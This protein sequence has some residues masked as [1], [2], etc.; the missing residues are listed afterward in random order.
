MP[1]AEERAKKRAEEINAVEVKD[2]DYQVQVHIVEVRDLKP[3][4]ANGTSDPIVYAEVMGRKQ[5]TVTKKAMTSCVFDHVMFF[6]FK[7]ITKEDVEAAIIKV[8]VFDADTL[9]RNDLIGEF[10]FDLLYVYYQKHH[11]VHNQ[12]VGIADPGDADDKGLQGYLKLSVVVLGPGDKLFVHDAAKE[13]A[14]AEAAKRQEAKGL[15]AL[16]MMPPALKRE[17]NFL[18]L[19]VYRA[20]GLPA[21]DEGLL[22]GGIDAFVQASFAGNPPLRT[23]WITAKGKGDLAVKWN[24]Q[25]WLP[26]MMPTMTSR[27]EVSVCVCGFCGVSG[28]R[29]VG[30]DSVYSPPLSLSPSFWFAVGCGIQISVWDFD[31]LAKNDR[32]GTAFLDFNQIK[33]HPMEPAWINIYGAPDGVKLGSNK[34]KM[35]KLPDF[36]TNYRC[37]AGFVPVASGRRC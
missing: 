4:D 23:K 6:N 10:S 3:E 22:K 15:D 26:V 5:H 35:N 11:E 30:H 28:R 1:A 19:T 24:E 2:G 36:A 14:D 20:E 7:A 25:M 9:S 27:I 21:M 13:A 18:V 17:L 16:L 33:A 8:S 37:V 29:C 32:V 12:W 31:R 34:N